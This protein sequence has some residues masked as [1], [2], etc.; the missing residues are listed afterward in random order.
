LRHYCL[1]YL[2]KT[3]QLLWGNYIWFVLS[4]KDVDDCYLSLL[5]SG[6]LRCYTS[7][8]R[9]SL[10]VKAMAP[11]HSQ[12][13]PIL[14][15]PGRTPTGSLPFPPLLSTPPLPHLFVRETYLKMLKISMCYIFTRGVTQ[16]VSCNLQSKK[17]I[18]L[19]HKIIFHP[20]LHEFEIDL[21]LN[22]GKW[23]NAKFQTK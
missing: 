6:P 5:F 11:A 4:Y 9:W 14:T 3:S 22:F 19:I 12:A 17:Q 18:L 15:A 13:R 1:R 21:Y 8:S 10:H 23:W 2:I 16:K 7:I 20:P